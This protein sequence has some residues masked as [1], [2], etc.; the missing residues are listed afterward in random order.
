M[1]FSYQ[2]SKATI[3]WNDVFHQR[4]HLFCYCTLV[5]I[6]HYLINYCTCAVHFLIW[7]LCYSISCFAK[8]L[9]GLCLIGELVQ[10][11]LLHLLSVRSIAATWERIV[12]QASR[13]SFCRPIKRGLYIWSR[14]ESL[15]IR[16]HPFFW[17]VCEVF[18]RIGWLCNPIQCG[19]SQFRR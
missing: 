19:Y 17:A 2:V 14:Q 16:C 6:N 1:R 15:H 13:V 7:L 5:S 12:Q 11:I 10:S 8:P 3:W 18:C 4:P 9:E